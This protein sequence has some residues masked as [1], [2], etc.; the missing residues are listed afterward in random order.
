MPQHSGKGIDVRKRKI[1][2]MYGPQT[3]LEVRKL[4]AP[5]VLLS[6]ECFIFVDAPSFPGVTHDVSDTSAQSEKLH[7]DYPPF[8]NL[9]DLLLSYCHCPL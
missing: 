2:D 6:D 4:E 7:L 1:W 3:V 9:A 5:P 8:L